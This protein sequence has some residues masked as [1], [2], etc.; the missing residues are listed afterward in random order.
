MVKFIK[1]IFSVLLIAMLA[2]LMVSQKNQQAYAEENG[3]PTTNLNE[4]LV[5]V[6]IDSEKDDQG[7]HILYPD[8]E[9]AVNFSFAETQSKQFDNE[10]ELVYTLPAGMSVGTIGETSFP[11]RITDNEGEVVIENNTFKFENNQLK[12]N[13]NKNDP[14]FIRLKKVAN[15]EFKIEIK[16]SFDENS[17]EIVF[18]EQVKKTFKF[19]TDADLKVTKKGRYDKESGE[20]NYTISIQ[21]IGVNKNVVV[22]DVI[23][24][25][26]LT[27]ANNVTV[28]SNKVDQ[29]NQT[30]KVVGNGFETSIAKMIN[31]EEIIIKY[32]AYVNHDNIFKTGSIDETKNTVTVRSDN[33]QTPKIIENNLD[34]KIEYDFLKK[35]RESFDEIGNNK[36]RASWKLLINSYMRKTMSGQVIE[37]RIDNAAQKRM[38]YTGTGIRIVVTKPD[39]SK[40]NR[41]IPWAQLQ[42]TSGVKGLSSWKYTIPDSDKNYKYE[43]FYTTEID[44]TGA[45]GSLNFRNWAASFNYEVYYDSRI[46][47]DI[48]LELEKQ[49][50]EVSGDKIKWQI[51]IKNFSEAGFTGNT[52]IVDD[53]PKFVDEDD[54]I[55]N[56]EIIEDS[57]EVTGLLEEESYRLRLPTN[58]QSNTITI[59]FFKDKNFN[60]QG[61]KPTPDGQKRDIIITFETKVNQEWLTLAA[62]SGYQSNEVH[63]NN[64]SFRLDTEGEQIILSASA[65]A[66]P[67]KESIEKKV[68]GNNSVELGGKVYPVYDYELTFYGISED[69]NV[70][71]DIFNTEFLKYYDVKQAVIKGIDVDGNEFEGGNV[72]VE[73]ST[74]G[75][76]MVL[77]DLPKNNGKLHPVYKLYYSLI[78]KD[79]AALNR[80]NELA[81]SKKGGFPLENIAKWKHLSSENTIVKHTYHPY[82]D[83]TVLEEP[84]L[85]NDYTAKFKIIINKAE[86]DISPHSDTLTIKD[87]MSDNLRLIQDSIEILPSIPTLQVGFDKQ[88]NTVTFSNVPDGEKIEITYSVKIL[89]KGATSYSN[90]VTL[91]DY[92][93]E[94]SKTVNIEALGGGSGS[95]PSVT[96]L[97][98]DKDDINQKLEGVEFQLFKI[99]NGA[100][101]AVKDKNNQDVKFITNNEGKILIEGD[102]QELGWVLWEN[103]EYLLK[104]TQTI[105]G[106]D[107]KET[108]DIKFTLNKLPENSSQ[109]SIV[110]DT[111]TVTNEK[112]KTAVTARKIWMTNSQDYPTIYLKLF[113]K[114]AN[115][116]LEEVPG[117]EVK[118][119]EN[120]ATEARWD[121][122]NKFDSQNNKY[123][124]SVKEMGERDGSISLLDKLYYVTYEET[125]ENEHTITNIGTQN[126]SV[127]KVWNDNNNQDGLRPESIKV[128]LYADGKK[129]GEPVTL[130][131]TD[132]W[133]YAWSE[134]PEK[135]A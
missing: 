112:F 24:G 18:N 109:Y 126:L 48:G 14:N 54:N 130:T 115:Q 135:A 1:H 49:A 59:E 30:T 7:N 119:L 91:G 133:T 66:I 23:T 76:N 88:S 132:N 116:P 123:I 68:L 134:L 92:S 114:V 3:V 79:E 120:G 32:T 128:Q 117:A 25:T 104:E 63:K 37:D 108:K 47:V 5:N 101:V 96:I 113:R 29:V 40:E 22:S 13:F 94:V 21:S 39:G 131:A 98:I 72:Q 122:L 46:N 36:Y 9:Y 55:M 100:E 73:N 81:L 99:E 65:I 50:I 125:S 10:S 64:I 85:D 38:V 80:L 27:F 70:I 89:G 53:I 105:S 60:I 20:V 6:D 93:H 35:I 16:A 4:L 44:M 97:K 43:V 118:K 71:K 124:Y 129:S 58:K 87:K 28:T 106:Y 11:I 57:L 41:D 45:P 95:N 103:T 82:I 69:T 8:G 2:F 19:N 77:T 31:N 56:D 75:I 62:K 107:I 12:V 26:A 83:K 84:T 17:E 127:T 90:A 121:N 111:I 61:L 67:K 102:Q 42:T 78:V 15:I 34:S 52:F 74:E 86:K 110:G 33:V 51:K